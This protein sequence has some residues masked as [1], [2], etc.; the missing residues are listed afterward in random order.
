MFFYSI[1]NAIKQVLNKGGNNEFI[2]LGFPIQIIV[3]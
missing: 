3:V 1:L 2:I